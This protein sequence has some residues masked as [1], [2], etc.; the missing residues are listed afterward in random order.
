MP[1]SAKD[2]VV[3]MGRDVTETAYEIIFRRNDTYDDGGPNVDV[4]ATS[5]RRGR[6]LTRKLPRGAKL[7]ALWNAGFEIKVLKVFDDSS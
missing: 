6:K 1:F 7:N 2:R 5:W 4:I 3:N